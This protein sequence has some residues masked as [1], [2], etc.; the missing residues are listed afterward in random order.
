MS[1]TLTR[2]T[3]VVPLCVNLSLKAEHDRAVAA[4]QDARNAAAQ[5]AREVSTEIRDAAA[6][7]Q[8]IEQQMRDHTVRF[9]LQALPRKKWAEFEVN[10]PARPDDETDKALGIDASALDAVLSG[11]VYGPG[12]KVAPT[13]VAVESSTGDP[14][15]FDPSTDWVPLADEMSTAQWN[16]FAL[17]VLALNRG[18]T[19]APFSP[20]ASLVIQRSEQT[21]K[22]PSA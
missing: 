9:T 4:L 10:H 5:D 2:A 14:V 18:V 3:K 17:A 16:D 12:E 20:A 13:I 8:A 22:R 19:A 15:P 1:L 11:A 21:S 6:A 7:V